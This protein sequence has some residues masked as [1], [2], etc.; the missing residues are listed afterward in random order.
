MF[1][2]DSRGKTRQ[3]RDNEACTRAAT[4]GIGRGKE[5]NFVG[6]EQLFVKG[7]SWRIQDNPADLNQADWYNSNVINHVGKKIMNRFMRVPESDLFIMQRF[8]PGTSS[9]NFRHW[10]SIAVQLGCF[11]GIKTT[12][13]ACVSPLDKDKKFFLTMQHF[14][15]TNYPLLSLH[16]VFIYQLR[17]QNLY[18]TFSKDLILL[19]SFLCCLWF[20]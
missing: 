5:N 16:V 4:K 1:Q 3:R 18:P 2:M 7:Q 14:E 8:G 9:Q 20:R 10:H 6:Y 13:L 19:C 15:I 17:P 12:G 11:G